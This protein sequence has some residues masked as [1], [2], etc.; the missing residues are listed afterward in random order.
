L[1]TSE[2]LKKTTKIYKFEGLVF[3]ELEPNGQ[4]VQRDLTSEKEK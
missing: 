1:P 3:Q 4:V 2:W